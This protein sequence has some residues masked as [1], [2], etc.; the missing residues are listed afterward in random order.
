MASYCWWSNRSVRQQSSF[1][2]HN[3]G[4]LVWL[5]EVKQKQMDW[6]QDWLNSQQQTSCM[7]GAILIPKTGRLCV[8]APSEH[9]A[10]MW[11]PSN[12]LQIKKQHF[13]LKGFVS[14]LLQCVR[15]HGDNSS[16]HLLAVNLFTC[17]MFQTGVFWALHNFPTLLLPLSQLWS[18]QR[19]WGK[20]FIILSLCVFQLNICQ[21]EL[22]N[23]QIMFSVLH[24]IL[25]LWDIHYKSV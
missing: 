18:T 13:D 22:A 23:Y 1:H 15:E 7:F 10:W 20:T 2:L 3:G 5:S 25:S 16:H 19:W 6:S 14:C 24:S 11:T 21:K 8:N 4:P 17:E 9:R 12:I